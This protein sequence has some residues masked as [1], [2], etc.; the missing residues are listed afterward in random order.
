MPKK[1]EYDNYTEDGEL[2]YMISES[3]D[4]A[5]EVICEKYKPVI[6]FYANKYSKLI[7]GKGIDYNDLYQEGL[8]GLITAINNYKEQKDIKFSSFAFMCIKRKIFTA[9]KIANRKKYSILNES[10]SLD[11]T[12]DEENTNGL[13]NIL[14]NNE[15]GIEDLLVSKEN[16]EYFRKRLN[17]D[18]TDFEKTVYELRINNFSY[19]EIAQS[20]DK[21]NKSIERTL[22]RIRIKIKDILDK[23]N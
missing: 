20:L 2:L 21:T 10:C 23:I 19:D 16:A 1:K 6:S 9:I 18:L 4:D 13:G 7:E 5:T 14:T 15:G 11:S 17:E 3:G 22:V 12:S 8:I